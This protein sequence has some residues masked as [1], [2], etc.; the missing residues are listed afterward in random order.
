M[1]SFAKLVDVPGGSDGIYTLPV[2]NADAAKLTEK[3]T[4]ILS[5]PVG[6]AAPPR[7]APLPGLDPGRADARH[8]TSAVPSKIVV[9]E[10]TN[11]LILVSGE[12][13][14]QRVKALVERLDIALEIEGGNAIHVYPLGSA[15]ADELA[16]TLTALIS[17]ARAKPATGAPGPAVRGAPPAPPAPPVPEVGAG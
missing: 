9:D 2:R 1:L 10:R 15:V 11:T 17:D 14:Y 13:G 6:G 4:A 8:E 5:L 12:A 16:K 7:P 3:L